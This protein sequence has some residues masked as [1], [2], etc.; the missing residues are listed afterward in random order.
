M[1]TVNDFILDS[2][3][4]LWRFQLKSVATTYAFGGG[5]RLPHRQLP[6]SRQL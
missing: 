2:G 4:R 5:H 6:Q 3:E 1:E